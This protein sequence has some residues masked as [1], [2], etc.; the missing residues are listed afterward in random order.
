MT[1]KQLNELKIPIDVDFTLKD[2]ESAYR[3]YAK[4]YHPDF[5]KSLQST[6]KM[7][8]INNAYEFLKSNFDEVKKLNLHRIKVEEETKREEYFEDFNELT[9]EEM[10]NFINALNS[11][12]EKVILDKKKEDEEYREFIKVYKKVMNEERIR[13]KNLRNQV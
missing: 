12:K 8:G 7:I 10:S 1:I 13:L 9:N 3:H 11:A 5:A 6:E 4:L 2:L